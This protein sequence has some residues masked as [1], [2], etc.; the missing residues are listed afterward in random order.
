MP[1]YLAAISRVDDP[2]AMAAYAK[3]AGPTVAAFGGKASVIGSI[4]E[5]LEGSLDKNRVAI[6]E[7]KDR[8]TVRAWFDSPEYQAA[9]ELRLGAGDFD[10]LIL[11]G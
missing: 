9:R 6:F 2:A 1:A 10:F 3:A 5:H 7:F 11:E 4:V 8:A